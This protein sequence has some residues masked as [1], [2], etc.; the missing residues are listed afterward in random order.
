M[1][2]DR[3]A[4][5]EG[6][7]EERIAVVTFGDASANHATAQGAF[8]TAGWAAHQHVPVPLLFVCEDNGIGIS[9]RTP[10]GWIAEQFRHRAGAAVLRT[11]TASISRTCGTWP[12]R[13]SLGPRA[14]EPAFLHVRTVRMMGHAGS[15]VEQTY[16]TPQE[17]EATEARDPLIATATMLID[18]GWPPRPSEVTALWRRHPRAA[19]GRS[20]TR[21]CAGPSS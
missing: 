11:P 16:R 4:R 13:P 5:F 15:D 6:R 12:A 2:L 10:T 1:A 19:S 8:N 20:P 7:R 21:R 3:R 9:T 18:A 17:I 14:A